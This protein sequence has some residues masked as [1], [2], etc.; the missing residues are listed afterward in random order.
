[1]DLVRKPV[2]HIAVAKT[3]DTAP[4][5]VGVWAAE[6]VVDNVRV[7]AGEPVGGR[8]VES[9]PVVESTRVVAADIVPAF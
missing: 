9:A 8:A 6:Q 2:A 1:M 7:G 5:V 4:A 3:G